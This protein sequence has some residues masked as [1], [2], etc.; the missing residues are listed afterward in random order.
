MTFDFDR[1]VDRTGSGSLKWDK[2]DGRDILPLWVADTDFRSPPAVVE[3]L[4]SRADH[5]VFGYG[6]A[7]PA[8]TE[9]VLAT[10]A[11]DWDWKVDPSWLVWLPGLVCGINVTCRAMAS[12]ETGWRL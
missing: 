9:A 2:Y 12:P 5:G 6:D 4:K 3:A 11:D 1:T 8:L 7:P 10:C